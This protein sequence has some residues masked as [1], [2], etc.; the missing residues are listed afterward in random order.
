MPQDLTFHGEDRFAYKS[1]RL[2]SAGIDF[3]HVYSF[4]FGRVKIQMLLGTVISPPK[5]CN[6]VLSAAIFS[7]LMEVR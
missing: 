3:T 6:T 4:D 7:L 5:K 2:V 1:V